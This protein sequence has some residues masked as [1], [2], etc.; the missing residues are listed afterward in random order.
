MTGTGV[1]PKVEMMR[2]DD[3]APT[4]PLDEFWQ[5]YLDDDNWWWRIS[6]VHH[7]D[8]FDDAMERLLVARELHP[9]HCTTCGVDN[10]KTRRILM[11]DPR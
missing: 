11:G 5:A 8:L 7:M 1:P 3:A 2:I 4:A 9:P 10:C 6:C